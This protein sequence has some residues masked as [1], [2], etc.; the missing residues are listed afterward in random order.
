MVQKHFQIKVTKHAYSYCIEY[1]LEVGPVISSAAVG[2]QQPIMT[3]GQQS[4]I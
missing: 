3:D 4:M 1:L 2:N